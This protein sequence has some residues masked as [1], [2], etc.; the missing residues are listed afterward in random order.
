M[1]VVSCVPPKSL[2]TGPQFH[3]LRRDARAPSPPRR[4]PADTAG[5]E[6]RW[7]GRDSVCPLPQVD[8]TPGLTP[9]ESNSCRP[10]VAGRPPAN[11]R[12]PL[13][14]GPGLAAPAGGTRRT[15]TRPGPGRNAAPS[16]RCHAWNGGPACFA[17]RTREQPRFP[18]FSP[19]AGRCPAAAGSPRASPVIYRLA[20]PQSPHYGFIKTACQRSAKPGRRRIPALGPD[21]LPGTPQP[22]GSGPANSAAAEEDAPPP[23]P[24]RG[25]HRR[26]HSPGTR[27]RG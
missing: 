13:A 20:S 22:A 26:S 2:L 7:F 14:A 3:F 18:T 19:T 17:Y 27:R 10:H 1:C 23:T 16:G 9:P 12:G 25:G 8:P 6:R 4:S 5:G 24:S 21:R 11:E 15:R